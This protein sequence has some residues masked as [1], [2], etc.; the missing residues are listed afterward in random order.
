MDDSKP[1]G[2]FSRD[3]ILL[4]RFRFSCFNWRILW[5]SRS[6]NCLAD[7]VVNET[8]AKNSTLYIDYSNLD[9]FPSFISDIAC[10][11]VMVGFDL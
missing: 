5:N 2:W 11:N 4:I 1:E 9:S 10:T 7:A 6:A 3:K 8:L